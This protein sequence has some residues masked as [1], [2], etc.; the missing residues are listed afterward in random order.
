M[1]LT[2]KQRMVLSILDGSRPLT[3][4]EIAAE[5]TRRGTSA[6]PQSAGMVVTALARRGLV[7]YQTQ[8][9]T[10]HLARVPT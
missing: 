10:Y 9:G 8:A 4:A 7:E 1:D 5:M 2:E 3:G 6:S